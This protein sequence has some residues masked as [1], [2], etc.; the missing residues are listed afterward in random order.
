MRND[1]PRSPCIAVCVLDDDNIC[2]GCY[3]S[4]MEIT[5][6]FMATDEQKRETLRLA[7]ER[8]QASSAIRL[9]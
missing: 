8:M 6:W 2:M 9:L 5:D 7:L 4:A 3:R 1:E